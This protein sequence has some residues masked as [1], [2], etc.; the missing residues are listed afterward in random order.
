MVA[1]AFWSSALAWYSELERRFVERPKSVMSWPTAAPAAARGNRM[2]LLRAPAA[3]RL[4][5]LES[6]AVRLRL[7]VGRRTERA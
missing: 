2:G 1:A 5:G 4:P 6:T 7:A 3:R